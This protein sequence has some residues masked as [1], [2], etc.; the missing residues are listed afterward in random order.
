MTAN[1]GYLTKHAF[2]VYSAMPPS[3]AFRHEDL[4]AKVDAT[5]QR[6]VESHYSGPARVESYT[7]MYGNDGPTVGHVACLLP[8]GARAWANTK[9]RAVLDAMTHE[10]FCGRPAVLDGTGAI[11]FG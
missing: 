9:D 11:S 8:S 10:E 4:Q 2:G 7:V 5:P 6:A 1:G 3:R